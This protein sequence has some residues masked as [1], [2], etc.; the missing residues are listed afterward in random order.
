[1]VWGGSSSVG[2]YAIQLGALSGLTVITTASPRN[3]DYVKNLG[4]T[5]VFDHSDPNVVNEIQKLTSG[6]LRYAIDTISPQTA[7]LAIKALGE[8]AHIV[9]ISGSPKEIPSNVT[10]YEI[11]GTFTPEDQQ[12]YAKIFGEVNPLLEEKRFVPNVVQ[13]EPNGLAGIGAAFELSAS[14]KISAKKL[15]INVGETP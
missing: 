14:G 8:N 7:E 15:I 4:A 12:L 13:V 11:L 10:K 3:F 2:S 5:Y 1:L 6:R 9:L